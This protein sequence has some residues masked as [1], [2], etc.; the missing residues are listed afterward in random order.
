[1]KPMLLMCLIAVVCTAATATPRANESVA[2]LALAARG[3]ARAV[4]LTQPGA[5]EPELLASRELRDHLQAVTGAQFEIRDGGSVYAGPAVIIGPGPAASR[6]FPDLDL[7]SFG[8]EE[9]VIRTSGDKLLL[10][11]GRPRG[12]LYAVFRFLQDQLGIRW[13]TPWATRVPKKATLTVGPLNVRQKPAFESRDP[14]WFPA[15]D[16]LWAIRN[17]SNSQHARIT[18][19]MGGKIVYK[20][21]VHTFFPLV[22]PEQHFAKHPEWYSLINGQRQYQGA[23]LCTTNPELRDYLV[24]RVR[25]WLKETPEARI[26][27]ISQNDWIGPCQCP[28]CKEIDDREGSHAGTMVALLNYIAGKLGP[29]FPNV[30]FDTLAYQYTRTAPKSIRPLPN[31]IIRLCSIECNFA[32]PLTDPSNASFARDIVD[33]N[34]LC[35]RLYVWDYTTNFSHYVMPHPNYFSLGPNVR[36]FHQ[37]GVKGLFEQGAYQSYGSEMSELRAWVLAQLLWNPYQ[38]DRK[39]IDEFL[40]G[41]YGRG[42][43]THIRA[44]LRLMA[45]AAKGYYMGCFASSAGPYL[46]Y[47][48]LVRA[49]RLMEQAERAAGDDPDLRWRVRQ[50]RLPLWYAWLVRWPV[51]RREALVKGGD[52]PVPAS[53]KAL[54]EQWLAVATGPGPA[55]WSRMTHVNEGGVTPEQFVARFA[56]DPPDPDVKALPKRRTQASAPAGLPVTGAVDIQDSLV[57]LINEWVWA[58]FRGDPTASDEIAVFMPANHHEWAFQVHSA[59]MPAKARK[60]R[61]QVYALVRVDRK[62][63]NAGGVAFTAGIWDGGRSA[64]MGSITVSVAD[65]NTTYK[66]FLIGTWEAGEGR[67]IWLAPSANPSL[68]GIWVDRLWLVPAP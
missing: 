9:L 8:D 11:G 44:Y 61:W 34:R 58:E 47:D 56:Q 13:W 31:V 53:R 64:D 48:V 63:A 5:A 16:G 24:E 1:M 30:A 7:S 6:Y 42:A 18:P 50:A 39:L 62:N 29:E 46:S 25:A 38:D 55:G 3:K 36:F 51:L 21:F 23:Q 65:V 19:E 22:P 43:A 4:I 28:N 10:A 45:Q 17:G 20:G 68:D 14:F 33:W 37:H 27:S 32:A 15:F 66:P 40:T 49:E 12:T 41:Y 67:Y 59:R 57:Q 60:G 2:K 35:D 52:W 54:A 26:V